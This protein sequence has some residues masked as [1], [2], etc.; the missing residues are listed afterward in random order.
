MS[1]VVH[2]VSLLPGFDPTSFE[3][4]LI[5]GVKKA[6]ANVAGGS[7]GASVTVVLTGLSLPKNYTVFVSP[8]QDATWW[9][10]ARTQSGFT[11]NLSPRLAANTLAAGTIDILVVA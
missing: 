11:V 7:A 2:S 3:D 4:R 6:L 5:L 9:I 1:K 8:G 10:S